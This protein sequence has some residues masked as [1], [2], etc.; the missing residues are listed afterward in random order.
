M[1]SKDELLRAAQR[2]VSMRRQRAI[3][4]A[5]TNQGRVREEIPG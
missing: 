2:A 3:M 5:R 4:A 1:Q